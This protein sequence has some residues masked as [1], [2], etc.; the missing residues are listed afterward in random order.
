MNSLYLYIS[1]VLPTI[2]KSWSLP[3]KC[4]LVGWGGVVCGRGGKVESCKVWFSSRSV[5]ILWVL[6]ATVCSLYNR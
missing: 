3:P 1:C 6:M 2:S 5:A 4:G